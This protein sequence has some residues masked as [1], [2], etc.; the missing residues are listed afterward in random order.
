MQRTLFF[1]FM[2]CALSATAQS[3]RID[4][5]AFHLDNL[6]LVF[7]GTVNGVETDFAFD[8]GAFSSVTN[9]TNNAASNILIKESKRKVLDAN[10]QVGKIGRVAIRELTVGRYRINNLNAVTAD[11]SYL[12]CASLLLLGQD[13]IKRFNWVIDF[14]KKLLYVS[15]TPFSVDAGMETWPLKYENN[16]PVIEYTLNGTV[17][18]KCL[19]DFGFTG[20]FEL[21]TSVKEGMALY[22]VKKKTNEITTRQTASMG[23]MGMGKPI[24]QNE[25]LIDSVYFGKTLVKRIP[26]AINERTDTK[27]GVRFFSTFCRRVIL[28]FETNTLHL[29]PSGNPI[30]RRIPFDATVSAVNGKLTISGKNMTPGSS[31]ASL[32]IDE[33]VKSVNGKALPEYTGECDFMLWYYG[34]RGDELIV[35]KLTGEKVTVKRSSQF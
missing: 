32:E 12:K 24:Q 35:E 34:F 20:I 4:T 13:V 22:E 7:K 2:L 23:L 5:V 33:E 26:V 9:S 17:H 11:M 30:V 16:R 25:F 18:K 19:I 14:E 15:E 29:S 6:L 21:N 27:I 3:P 1:A 10:Q 8:T 31:A 28:N